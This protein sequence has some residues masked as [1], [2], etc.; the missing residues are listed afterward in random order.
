[1]RQLLYRLMIILSGISGI[2]SF[3]VKVLLKKCTSEQDFPITFTSK[4][5]FVISKHPLYVCGTQ[6]DRSVCTVKSKDNSVTIND[7]LMPTQCCYI[8]PQL[9]KEHKQYIQQYILQWFDQNQQQLEEQSQI[10]HT[11]F[12]HFVD[13]KSVV[14]SHSYDVLIQYVQTVVHNLLEQFIEQMGDEFV[15]SLQTLQQQADQFILYRV[16][17]YF[18]DQLADKKLAKKDRKLLQQNKQYRYQFFKKH[19]DTVIQKVVQEYVLALPRNVLSKFLQS[20]VGHITFQGHNYLGSFV[21]LREGNTLYLINALDIDDYLLSVV[22]HEG[23][24]GWP[25][26]VNKVL[27]VTCRTYL[28]WQVL[29]AQ[30]LKR[31]YHIE[32]GIRHQTYKGH[33]KYV[34]LKQAV[35]QTRDICIAADGKPILAM[36]DACCGGIVPGNIESPDYKKHPYLVRQQGCTYCK[37]CKVATWNLEV[38]HDDMLASLQKDIPTLTSIDEL[39]VVEKDPAGLAKKV[40]IETNDAKITIPGK[41][42]YTLFPGVKSF[43]FDIDTYPKKHLPKKTYGGKKK[44][45]M[46]HAHEY[47]GEKRFVL[48]GKGYGHH[49]GLC[50][51]GAMKL[52]KDHHWN[53]QKILQFYY[54]NTTL[55]KLSYQR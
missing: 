28:V 54:P 15:V 43:S 29:Q 7:T 55:I 48:R 11:F 16:K 6:S 24:P 47:T 37:G 34:R 53:Y 50:Q 21:L 41:R 19:V 18:L 49:V 33:H 46:L 17:D 9:S 4:T 14:G 23:W 10:L 31:P 32:N 2:Y 27:A 36:F 1:M 38:P 39:S 20:D 51:W 35:E 42:L 30:R 22:R 8:S 40:L 26:E 25:L 45:K 44:H 13:K 52:V 3:E 5:G 12:D